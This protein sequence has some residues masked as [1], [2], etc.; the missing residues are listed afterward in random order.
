LAS[1]GEGPQRE[2]FEREL[3][4]IIINFFL[5]FLI[6]SLPSLKLYRCGQPAIVI[7]LWAS[8][9]MKIR[10]MAPE[11]KKK[12]GGWWQHWPLSFFGL[13]GKTG[14]YRSTKYFLFFEF[15]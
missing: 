6:F 10:A 7:T 8:S 5:S 4:E 3:F 2:N 13:Y 1:F 11:A 15:K 14:I 12:G 9:Y